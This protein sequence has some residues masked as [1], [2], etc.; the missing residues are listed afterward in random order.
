MSDSSDESIE[1]WEEYR[2]SKTFNSY[3][4]R[5]WKEEK[6]LGGGVGR[7]LMA[8]WMLDVGEDSVEIMLND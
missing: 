6:E 5:S 3:S 7:G 2:D 4:L 1:T 8:R